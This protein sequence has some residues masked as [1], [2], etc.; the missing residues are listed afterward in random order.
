MR[1]ALQL[2]YRKDE[3]IALRCAE[4]R[5]IRE[6]CEGMKKLWQAAAEVVGACRGKRAYAFREAAM[7]ERKREEVVTL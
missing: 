6:S 2:K 3:A 4:F 5:R 1:R 7:W